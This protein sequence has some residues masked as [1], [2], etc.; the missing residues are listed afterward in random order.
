MSSQ[1]SSRDRIRPNSGRQKVFWRSL[2][3]KDAPGGLGEEAHGSD[4]VKATIGA[5]ELS[6]LKR[7]TFLTLSGAI[8]A[9]AG[10]EGCIRRPVEKILPYT[11]PPEDVSPGVPLHY[12]SVMQ[13]PRR[14]DRLARAGVRRPADQD[15]RQPRA[16]GQPRLDRPADAGL[17]PGSLRCRSRAH[18]DALGHRQG[19]RRGRRAAQ[20]LADKYGG[21]GGAGLRVLAQPT[22]SPSFLR[23]RAAIKQRMPSARFHTYAPMND[24]NERA[25]TKIAFGQTLLVQP[26]IEARA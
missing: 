11:K 8:S 26:R 9:M 15:R 14:G 10:L 25:G 21:S 19:L 16:P 5:Q 12:A 24:S 23:M 13:S 7:R 17:D 4:V 3:E 22:N 18:A 6:R 2:E 20:G 1:I